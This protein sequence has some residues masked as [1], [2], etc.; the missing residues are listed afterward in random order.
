MH[1]AGGILG[2]HGRAPKRDE[3]VSGI[4]ADVAGQGLSG[5]R[6]ME[7]LETAEGGN[8]KLAGFLVAFSRID[9]GFGGV[10]GRRCSARHARKTLE[11]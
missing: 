2:G 8:F 10:G 11:C 4:V 7:T 1:S 9:G 6:E 3:D 5:D